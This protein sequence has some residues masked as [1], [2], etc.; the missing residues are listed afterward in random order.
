[1]I[2]KIF[3]CGVTLFL[4]LMAGVALAENIPVPSKKDSRILTVKYREDDVIPLTIAFDTTFNI[5]FGEDE[6]IFTAQ[7]GDTANWELHLNKKAYPNQLFIKPAHDASKT[8]FVVLTDEHAY[9]FKLEVS[10]NISASAYGLKFTYDR[11]VKLQTPDKIRALTLNKPINTNYRF[12]GAPAFAPVKVF[13]DGQ[14][15]YFEFKNNRHF[16]AIFAVN[17]QKGEESIANIRQEG[18]TLI[19]TRVSPQ[20]T[21]RNGSQVVSVFNGKLIKEI[22]HATRRRKTTRIR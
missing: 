16:P 22:K 19:A 10:E 15:T 1:M 3:K 18:N 11:Q 12:S 9:F 6:T 4:L 2:N 5:K 21:L 17:S 7:S 14:F 20:W 13:D 8:N